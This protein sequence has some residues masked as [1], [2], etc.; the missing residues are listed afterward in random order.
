M[1]RA[2]DERTVL[3]EQQTISQIG[4]FLGNF[5]K[6]V[7]TIRDAATTA[8]RSPPI[9]RADRVATKPPGFCFC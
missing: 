3:H 9:R 4:G 8:P 7:V 2:G 1:R 5:G 6:I